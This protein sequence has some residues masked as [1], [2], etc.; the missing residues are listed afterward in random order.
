MN[1]FKKVLN[2]IRKV[3]NGKDREI[4]ITMLALLA[5]GNILIEDI[6]G[7]GK[8]T[9]V[10]AFSKALGL[11]YGRIQFT[12]DTLPSDITGFSSFNKESGKMHFNKG[13]IFCNLFLADELNRTSSRTQAALLEAMEERQV[14][15][16][17]HSYAL[18]KP[19]S[20]IATQNPV[21]ASGT[22]LLPDSQTDRFTVR[23]SMGYPDFD[24]E[25]QMLL[26]RS[27]QNPL[28][29]VKQAITVDELIDMQNKVKEV[30]VSEDM[31]KYIVMLVTATRQS[32]LF[33]RG[34][35]PRATLSLKDMAKAAAFAD[36]RDYV[37]PRDIQNI[38]VSTIS[39]RVILSS[40]STAKRI[41]TDSALKEILRTTRQPKI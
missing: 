1:E 41:N 2:E 40:E 39:H 27:K 7:V 20:V 4:I 6:P 21:G 18:E 5:N 29:N 13:A 9:L 34:A 36:G 19:F 32:S 23:I 22:Q 17:G 8:T 14:T 11:K 3:I 26:N 35:S 38:F 15:V 25:C 24:A 12:P 33:S 10:L 28:D 30:F 16:D 37:V 31:A